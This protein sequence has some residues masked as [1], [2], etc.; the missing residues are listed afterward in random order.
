M[1][2]TTIQAPL[3]RVVEEETG[4]AAVA[5]ALFRTPWRPWCPDVF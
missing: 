4:V 5:D 2:A 1:R 3:G